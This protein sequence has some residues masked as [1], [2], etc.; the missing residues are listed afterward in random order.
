MKETEGDFEGLDGQLVRVNT[1]VIPPWANSRHYFVHKMAMSLEHPAVTQ[2]LHNWI[3]LIFGE[4]QQS[5]AEY[6]LFKPLTSEKYVREREGS[7]KLSRAEVSQIVEFGSNPIQI[8]D[9]PN[10]VVDVFDIPKTLFDPFFPQLSYSNT[11]FKPKE[12]SSITR[13]IVKDRGT[14]YTLNT[15][16]EINRIQYFCHSQ[17]RLVAKSEIR[18]QYHV[19]T[20][21]HSYPVLAK[22]KS[23]FELDPNSAFSLTSQYAAQARLLNNSFVIY[24]NISMNKLFSISFHKAT[25]AIDL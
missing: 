25:L 2:A 10:P 8:L 13:I 19:G 4:K 1:V 11:P 17:H 18:V 23:F 5:E 3:D 21:L 12:L 15:D 7:E 9:K 14:I 22:D 24:N 20:L 6:N 16:Y